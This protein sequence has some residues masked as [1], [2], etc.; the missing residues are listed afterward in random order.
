MDIWRLSLAFWAGVAFSFFPFAGWT[1]CITSTPNQAIAGCAGNL[2]PNPSFEAV[3][4][5]ACFDGV[6]GDFW[7]NDAQYLTDWTEPSRGSSDFYHSCNAGPSNDG[8]PTNNF[9]TQAPR[10]GNGYAHFMTYGTGSPPYREYLQTPLTSPMVAGRSY[11]ISFYVSKTDQSRWASNNIGAH[12]STFPVSTN[13]FN[14]LSVTAHVLET[15]V[16]TD[17]SNWTRISGVYAATGGEQYL[18]IGN[19][20]SDPAT[21]RTDLG[22]FYLNAGYYLDDVCVTDVSP[23]DITQ[24]GDDFDLPGLP[25]SLSAGLVGNPLTDQSQLWI[26]TP[27]AQEILVDLFA[28]DGRVLRSD[29]LQVEAGTQSFNWFSGMHLAQGTYLLQ[30]RDRTGQFQ[31]R[32][33]AVVLGN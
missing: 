10:T 26:S 5:C 14:V 4:T 20:F 22:L 13:T 15:N 16:I 25:G 1:Q 30:V 11:E 12:V 28:V 23:L 17:A 32:F 27:E 6:T 18:T 24:Q 3:D 9:G 31:Q 8:V 33:R 7:Y 19:F 29:Q 2:V 21:N